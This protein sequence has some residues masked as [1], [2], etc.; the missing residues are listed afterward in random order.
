MKGFSIL[1]VSIAETLTLRKSRQHTG[2]YAFLAI[3]NA[4][5]TPCDPSFKILRAPYRAYTL[6]AM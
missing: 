3:C 4:I 1:D 2:F 5:D 6:I